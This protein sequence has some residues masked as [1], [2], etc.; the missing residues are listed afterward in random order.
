M[1]S[2]EETEELQRWCFQGGFQRLGS[3][4]FRT[5]QARPLGCRKLR[6]SPNP[7]LRQKAQFYAKELRGACPAFLAGSLRCPNAAVRHWIGPLEN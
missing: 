3:S 4:I 6:N 7:Q 2:P 1:L 5:L